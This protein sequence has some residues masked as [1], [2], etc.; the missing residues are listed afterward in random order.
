MNAEGTDEINWRIAQSSATAHTG[1]AR[2]Q[3]L[4]RVEHSHKQS[5][6]DLS[7][8]YNPLKST[9]FLYEYSAQVYV[10]RRYEEPRVANA[11]LSE[12]VNA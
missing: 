2:S 6:L 5:A 3:Y 4:N 9:T 7:Q 10:I 12:C 1:E 11:H 8:V